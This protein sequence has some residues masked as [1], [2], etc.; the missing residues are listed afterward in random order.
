MSIFEEGPSNV[1]ADW[2]QIQAL[3]DYLAGLDD[4]SSTGGSIQK[5]GDGSSAM[6]DQFIGKLGPKIGKW[7]PEKTSRMVQEFT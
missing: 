2:D 6:E 5:S 4:D 3:L 7:S 1:E